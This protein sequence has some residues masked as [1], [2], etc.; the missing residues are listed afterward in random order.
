MARFSDELLDRLREAAPLELVVEDYVALKKSGKHL[1]GLCPF[2][3]EKTPSFT[4][5]PDTGLFYC[6][7]CHKGGN[8]FT[9]LMEVESLSFP[10]VVRQLA[11]R[12]GVALPS[13]GTAREGMDILAVNRWAA[14]VFQRFLL[15]DQ[16][17]SSAREY[18][19]GRNL[20]PD[21]IRAFGLG[22]SSGQWQFLVT[23][24]ER[25][26]IPAGLLLEAGLAVRR[27]D[28]SGL[29][30]RFRDRL[31]F[32]LHSPSGQVM[33]FAG[34][35]L[36]GSTDEAKYVNSPETSAY[37]KGKYVFGM[38]QARKAMSEKGRALLVEGYFDVMRCHERGF[39]EAVAVSGTALTADQ[40]TLLR[41]KTAEVIVMFD[42][43]AAGQTAAERAV[44][45]LFEGSLPCRVVVL[46]E[47]D[48]PD[49][50]LVSR[51]PEE[52]EGVLAGACPAVQ[53]LVTRAQKR[54]RRARDVVHAVAPVMARIQDPLLRE[55]TA[56]ELARVLGFTPDA[57]LAAI[58]QVEREGQPSARGSP[59]PR[60]P[61]AWEEQVC[62]HLLLR[63]AER[64]HILDE[65][66]SGDFASPDLRR[67]CQWIVEHAGD[68]DVRTVIEEIE[69]VDLRTRAT[70]LAVSETPLGP[71][72][73]DV[74]RFRIEKLV[75][76]MRETREKISAAEASGATREVHAL[77]AELNDLGGAVDGLRRALG[78]AAGVSERSES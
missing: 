35:T 67:L 59:A 46:P 70:A 55:E 43:D 30:D 72:E 75:R 61:A 77:L 9:F 48:D 7:G 45:L 63:P 44:G 41:R 34:R 28:G 74:V 10:D 1:K 39:S 3:T 8:V 52:F 21:S 64:A 24:A 4:V 13:D 38:F 25:D 6:Y 56:R 17:G 20:Q 33:A 42:G 32:P 11:E 27:R 16:A 51:A 69:D 40:V 53:F 60:R 78:S 2:H 57:V 22:A 26:G 14:D 71:V 12:F 47:G 54:K 23:K 18:L 50:F 58:R 68:K 49:S 36:P 31:M 5:S 19:R 29:L 76:I 15:S 66:T 65:V 62:R 73:K 37:H